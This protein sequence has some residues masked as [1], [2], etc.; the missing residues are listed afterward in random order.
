MEWTKP[1]DS[2]CR[3]RPRRA[4][5]IAAAVLA[6]GG[7]VAGI[8]LLSIRYGRTAGQSR[9]AWL[10]R[11]TQALPFPRRAE[12]VGEPQD[13]VAA[14]PSFWIEPEDDL[15]HIHAQ[16]R[17][18]LSTLPPPPQARG[19][20]GLF[21]QPAARPLSGWDPVRLH[22]EIEHIFDDARQ[23]RECDWITRMHR[24]WDLAPGLAAMNLNDEGGRYLVSVE[25]PGFDKSQITVTLEGR[26]LG[27]EA[28][29]PGGS[30]DPRGSRFQTQI[31]LPSAPA[32]SGVEAVFE[33]GVL[34]VHIPK[35]ASNSL[36]RTIAIR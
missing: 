21:F 9:P 32:G 10:S 31:L 4:L 33:Q 23:N 14:A 34:R 26:L 5:A 25:L 11:W 22:R 29:Q 35:A 27:V 3:G 12:P 13:S 24:A 17:S 15:A 36:A 7:A 8:W 20:A 19:P 1:A 16:I 18:L 6:L 30:P 2:G 28:E